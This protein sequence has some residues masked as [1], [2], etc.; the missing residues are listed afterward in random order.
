MVSKRRPMLDGAQR[1][2]GLVRDL[3]NVVRE[4]NEWRHDRDAFVAMYIDEMRRRA[5]SDS[6]PKLSG[7][8][9]PS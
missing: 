3:F 5:A 4:V 1:A 8:S 6:R 2:A 7:G 9:R